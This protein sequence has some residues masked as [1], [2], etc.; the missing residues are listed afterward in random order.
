SKTVFLYLDYPRED[1]NN[2][3][4]EAY[5][6][7]HTMHDEHFGIGVVEMADAGLITVANNSA[8]PAMDIL[9]PAFTAQNINKNIVAGE[10]NAKLPCMPCTFQVDQ[11]TGFLA[12]DID[13]YA[14]MIVAAIELYKEETF[15]LAEAKLKTMREG[16]Q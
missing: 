1:L 2:L 6:G 8:G 5:I 12:D 7:I 10:S 9:V 14:S 13:S 15:L 11:E 16:S 3:L 4:Q